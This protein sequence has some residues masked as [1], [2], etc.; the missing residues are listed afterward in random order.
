LTTDKTEN[1]ESERE[2]RVLAALESLFSRSRVFHL[3][4]RDFALVPAKEENE[5]PTAQSEERYKKKREG[6][7]AKRA[8]GV[9]LERGF[10]RRRLAFFGV[11][12]DGERV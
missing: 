4:S 12:F 11:S 3:C 10:Q 9:L 6:E 7:E 5:R 8:V 2:E 1:E